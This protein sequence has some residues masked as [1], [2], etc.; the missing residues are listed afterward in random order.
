MLGILVPISNLRIEASYFLLI[1]MYKKVLVQILL[2][3]GSSN[4][5]HYPLDP[6]LVDDLQKNSL[7]CVHVTYTIRLMILAFFFIIA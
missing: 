4:L 7:P 5:S 3:T 6:T 1:S 2:F